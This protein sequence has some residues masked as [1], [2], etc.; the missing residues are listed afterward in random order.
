[1]A[2]ATGIVFA[3]R[4]L[5]R[6][7]HVRTCAGQVSTSAYS[8]VCGALSGAKTP[9]IRGFPEPWGAKV[10][11]IAGRGSHAGQQAVDFADHLPCALPRMAGFYPRPM[12]NPALQ[13]AMA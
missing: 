5:F 10:N 7:H 4:K 1:M 2:E 8:S 6:I 3:K 9:G 11:K 12:G 13:A